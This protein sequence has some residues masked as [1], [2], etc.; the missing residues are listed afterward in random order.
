MNES[1]WTILR[2]LFNV[3]IFR[4]GACAT[5]FGLACTG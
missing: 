5:P 1:P 3:K 4:H 2:W